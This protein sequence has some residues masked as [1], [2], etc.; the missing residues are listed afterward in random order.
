M[1]PLTCSSCGSKIDH[2][3][4][5]GFLANKIAGM[6]LELVTLLSQEESLLKRKFSK[7]FRKKWEEDEVLRKVITDKIATIELDIAELQT[8]NKKFFNADLDLY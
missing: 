7:A 5:R 3:A 6:G 1:K 4:F 8:V 2:V